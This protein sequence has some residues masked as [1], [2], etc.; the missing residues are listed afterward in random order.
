MAQTPAVPVSRE[1]LRPNTNMPA[2]RALPAGP[3]SSRLPPQDL[4]AEMALLGS[5]MLD[6][7]AVGLVLQ[8]I[9]REESS[10]LYRP[11]HQK[12]FTALID[13]YDTGRAMDLIV[14]RD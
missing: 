6:R 8:V 3:P 11:D 2:G 7:E 14:V 4:Q 10:R 1:S 12:L 5:M 9:P 13:V